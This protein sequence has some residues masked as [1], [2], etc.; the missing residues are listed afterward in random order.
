MI[1]VKVRLLLKITTTSPSRST[2]AVPVTHCNNI[3]SDE[4]SCFADDTMTCE[5]APNGSAPLM[6]NYRDR[7]YLGQF[8]TIGKL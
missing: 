3:S 8:R 7:V 6:I 2:L 4:G 5:L 1:S